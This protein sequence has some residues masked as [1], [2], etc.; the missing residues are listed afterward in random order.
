MVGLRAACP[1]LGGRFCTV[2]INAGV[3]GSTLRQVSKLDNGSDIIVLLNCSLE[4]LSYFS[5]LGMGHYLDSFQVAYSLKAF[6]G[7]GSLIKQGKEKWKLYAYCAT[8]FDLIRE[9]DE[10]PIAYKVEEYL[11]LSSHQSRKQLRS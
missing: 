9:F 2:L 5:K 1:K 6:L 4:R 8:G 3:D 10:R 11:R 7:L